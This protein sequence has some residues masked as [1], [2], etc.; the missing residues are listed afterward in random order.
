[1]KKRSKEPKV[2]KVSEAKGK[3]SEVLETAR[4]DGP[5]IIG[6]RNQCV[7]V[8]REEWE[9]QKQEKRHL[10]KWLIENSPKIDFDFELPDRKKDWDR[11]NPFIEEE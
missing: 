1:M 4:K 9:E 3:L 8:S 5:Q 11:P 6:I 10:G 2:W 7:V